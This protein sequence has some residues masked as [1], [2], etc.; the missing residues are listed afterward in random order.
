MDH[1]TSPQLSSDTLIGSQ[2]KSGSRHRD[3]M[4]NP[5]YPTPS[6][7]CDLVVGNASKSAGPLFASSAIALQSNLK[8][9]LETEY[10]S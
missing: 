6:I 4:A 8:S 2:L 1:A 10:A 5:A 9:F 3:A 7:R